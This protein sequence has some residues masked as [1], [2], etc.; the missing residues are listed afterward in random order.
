[1]KT[2]F[3]E[4]LWTIIF[5]LIIYG[6]IGITTQ[7]Y[8][9][10]QTSMYPTIKPGERFVISKVSYRLHEPERGD[11]IILR[12]PL[13]PE[14]VPYIKRIVGLPNET[15][16]IKEGITYINGMRLEEPYVK[17]MSEL[18]C[19]AVMIPDGDYYVMG[20]NRYASSDSRNWGMLPAENIIGKAWLCYWPPNKLGKAPNYS[21]VLVSGE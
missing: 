14:A 16:E 2:L 18:S 20:D 1:M 17:K 13:N 4:I 9:I 11:I 5:A 10:E 21:P 15:I 12:P 19:E 8:R 7:E 3:R 6:V